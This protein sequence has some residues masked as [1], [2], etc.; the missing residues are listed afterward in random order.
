[1]DRGEEDFKR[2]GVNK[3][4]TTVANSMD[5]KSVVAVVKDGTRL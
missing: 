1:M 3:W 4:N 2:S 5:W